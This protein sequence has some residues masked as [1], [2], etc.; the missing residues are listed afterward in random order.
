[1]EG[2][3]MNRIQS[4]RSQLLETREKYHLGEDN[5]T[6]AALK[7]ELEALEDEYKQLSEE[8]NSE[9]GKIGIISYQDLFK[10]YV[11]A[12][13]RRVQRSIVKRSI[14]NEYQLKRSNRC[15]ITMNSL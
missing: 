15:R 7:K 4:T 14:R 1:M 12:I 3:L 2:S 9:L 6:V 13:K 11:S 8:A 10:S 5:P